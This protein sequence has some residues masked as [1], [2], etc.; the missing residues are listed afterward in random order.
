M[1]SRLIVGVVNVQFIHFISN[2][3]HFGILF[4]FFVYK[5]KRDNFIV[6]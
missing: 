6:R 1:I 5:K 2:D 4:P 3:F